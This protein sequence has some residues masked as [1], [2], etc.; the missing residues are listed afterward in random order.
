MVSIVVPVYNASAFLND[1]LNSIY[2]QDYTDFE[3]L[4]VDDGST[5]N[6]LSICSFYAD[7]DNRFKVFSKKNNGVSSARN[8]AIK[9]S[10]GEYIC[11]VDS[12]DKIAPNYLSTLLAM[13]KDGDFAICGYTR[14]EKELGYDDGGKPRKYNS[15]D[16][17]KLIYTE[18]IIHPNLWMMLFRRSI[19]VN[20]GIFFTVGCIRTEDTEFYTK[21]L[22]YED[23]V[24]CSDYK[25]YFYRQNDLSQ[26]N[27]P[28]S[29][30]TFSTSIDA[31]NR[32]DVM[33]YSNRIIPKSISFADNVILTYAYLIA[34]QKDLGLYE[35]FH[36]MYDVK[37]AIKGMLHYPVL[38]KRVLA[39]VYLFIGSKNF[40]RFL[41]KI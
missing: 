32:I 1:C 16:F 14:N 35:E 34:R 11:F 13:S 23:K 3:V 2:Q 27:T 40:F 25:G 33:L 30:K 7:K 21:Y 26:M 28:V 24:V 41:S 8:L 37:S 19:I 10:S 36:G 6:S 18:A 29:Y 15:R 9:E 31:S 38:R 12:D 20:N 17:L 4:C 22:L 39:F 5:D